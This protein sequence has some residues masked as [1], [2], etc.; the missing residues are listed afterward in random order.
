MRFYYHIASIGENNQRVTFQRRT[1]SGEAVSELCAG[2]RINN[3][4][5]VGISWVAS[6]SDEVYDDSETCRKEEVQ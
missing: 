2:A 3:E 1:N 5:I 6:G 4:K